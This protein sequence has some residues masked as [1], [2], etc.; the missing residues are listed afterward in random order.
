L[1]IRLT[2]SATFAAGLLQNELILIS[3]GE[4]HR[5]FDTLK[6]PT[7]PREN[8]HF[9]AEQTEGITRAFGDA[10]EKRI[11]IREDIERADTMID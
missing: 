7:T 1:K 10:Y 8:A 2:A 3:G 5:P 6:L 11:A 4:E 9:T